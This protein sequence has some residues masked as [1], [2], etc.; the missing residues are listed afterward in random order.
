MANEKPKAKTTLGI[1]SETE[2]GN[3][4]MLLQDFD[5]AV[6]RGVVACAKSGKKA[7]I[8]MT[9][10]IAPT[11]FNG[12]RAQAISGSVKE[13]LPKKPGSPSHFFPDKEGRLYSEDIQRF[14]GDGGKAGENIF[15]IEGRG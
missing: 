3:G 9:V 13:N 10:V 5:E 12:G 8:T 4:K 11:T 15:P 14:N 1:L 6:Q 2:G 7:T